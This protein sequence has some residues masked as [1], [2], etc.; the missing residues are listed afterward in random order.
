MQMSEWISS[1][2]LVALEALLK[3]FAVGLPAKHDSHL[4]NLTL[5]SRSKRPSVA[6]LFILSWPICLSLACHLTESQKESLYETKV[7]DV[8]LLSKQSSKSHTRKS[9]FKVTWPNTLPPYITSNASIRELKKNP[10]FI[11][12]T[13]GKRQSHIPGA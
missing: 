8:L 13:K 1:K 3:G 10:N 7:E 9:L 4:G 12:E 2:G 5:V 11:K 6:S